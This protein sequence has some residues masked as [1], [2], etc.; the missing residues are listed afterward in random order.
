MPERIGRNLRRGHLAEWIG[1]DLFRPFASVAQILQ[2]DDLGIDAIVTL[3]K[4]EGGLLHARQAMYVQ[5]KSAN[6][7]LIEYSPREES[8]LWA[9]QLP[10]FVGTAD[11]ETLR[12]RLYSTHKALD[13]LD[14]PRGRGVVLKLGEGPARQLDGGVP[15]VFLGAPVAEWTGHEVFRDETAD[16][17]F[18]VLHSWC[19]ALDTNRVLRAH[20]YVHHYEWVTNACP[21]LSSAEVSNFH[22]GAEAALELAAPYLCVLARAFADEPGFAT[23]GLRQFLTETASRGMG[24]RS[25]ALVAASLLLTKGH[26]APS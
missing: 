7:P 4:R 5:M 23:D 13:D 19:F 11:L 10:F 12:V 8:W 21:V 26:S 2:E 3:L 1:L 17:I 6:V 24:R 16:R 15:Q 25:D 9:Q 18:E 22:G 14:I 20:G